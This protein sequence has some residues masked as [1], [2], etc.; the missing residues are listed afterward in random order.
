MANVKYLH[1]YKFVHINF[2]AQQARQCNSWSKQLTA[3]QIDCMMGK[4]TNTTASKQ[5][6]SA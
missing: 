2:T 3:L 5:T 4:N 6:T 1:I